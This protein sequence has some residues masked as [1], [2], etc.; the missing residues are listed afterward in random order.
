MKDIDNHIQNVSY[1]A[2]YVAAYTVAIQQ[3]VNLLIY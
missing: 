2:M 3:T 1:V